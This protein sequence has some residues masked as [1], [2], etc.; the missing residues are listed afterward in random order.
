MKTNL[1]A[2]AAGFCLALAF[3]GASAADPAAG[4]KAVAKTMD[5][6]A[7]MDYKA[8]KKNC[9]AMKGDAEKTCM[10]EAKATHEKAEA[11]AR[12]VHEMSEAKT[13]KERAEVTAKNA[14][15]KAEADKKVRK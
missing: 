3:V 6:Q 12:G 5:K 2:L 8:A 7:D 11:D 9:E 13:P 1:A 4:D 15:E 10:R 14:E